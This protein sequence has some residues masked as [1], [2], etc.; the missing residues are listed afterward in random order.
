MWRVLQAAGWLSLLSTGVA[1]GSLFAQEVPAA[2]LLTAAETEFFEARIRPVLVEHCYQCHAS[3]GEGIKGGLRLDHLGGW[4]TGGDSGPAVLP[5]NPEESLLLQAMKYESYEMPPDGQ[6]PVQV[7]ADFEK[8]IQMGAPDPRI[9]PPAGQA[10]IRTIDLATERN[11]WSFQP[12]QASAVPTVTDALWPRTWIDRYIRA[13]QEQQQVTP[14]PDL[15]FERL[16]RRL[17]YDLVGL[18][19]SVEEQQQF[20]QLARTDLESALADAVDRRIESPEFGMHWGRHW[21]DVARYADS[22]GGDFNATFHDAWRYRDYVV[23]SYNEDKPFDQFIREQVA[24]D[25]LPAKDDAQREEQI[26]ATGFLMIGPK[27]LSERD[28]DKLRM[29]IV[30]EQISSV[31]SAFLGMT[32]GCCRCH[33]HKF[34]PIPTNDYYALAGIFRSTQVLDGESQKYV[35]DFTRVDLPIEADHA[36][37]LERHSQRMKSI[38]KQLASARKKRDALKSK[39]ASQQSLG[40]LVDDPQAT[41][42]G[43]WTSSTNV[44]PWVGAGYVHD[45]RLE[46]G[47]KSIT[48]TPDLKATGEYEV[49]FSFCYSSGRDTQV[50]VRIKHAAG[51]SLVHVD[52][53]REPPID[54]LFVVLGRFPF[55]AGQTGS[56]TISNTGTTGYV[57][58]DAVQFIPVDELEQSTPDADSEKLAAA[59]K[60]AGADVKRI[61]AE[62][63]QA[64]SE[65]PPR[66]PQ[67]IAVREATDL[68]D[69][70]VCIRGEHQRPGAIVPRGFLQVAL[71]E[72]PPQIPDDA[73]GRREL[74]DWLADPRNP[75]TA[76]VYVNRIWAHLLGEGLVRTTDNF[77]TLGD[78]P[79]HPQLLDRLA[80]Q[81]IL[82]GWSTKHLV[83]EIMLS[84]VY[85]Q[86][87]TDRPDVFRLDPENRLLW[88]ANRKRLP[89]EA[90]RDTML[91]VSG[92]LDTATGGS[93]VERLGVLVST[94]SA[95]DKGYNRSESSRRSLYMPIIRN[96]IPAMLTAFDFA[97]PDFV[98]GRRNET[99]VPAQALLLLN[100]PFVRE[101]AD[102]SAARLLSEASGDDAGRVAWA[103]E[104]ALCRTPSGAEVDRALNFVRA[105]CEPGEASL[106]SQAAPWSRLLQALFA[107]TEFR[108]LD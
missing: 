48:Y 29:D 34:D 97:D 15:D 89:A 95:S 27:M 36:A 101:M 11:F 41:K 42:V 105:L 37:A 21:L 75:L 73:S 17:S 108:L 18:P 100:S 33:D 14:S 85:R 87:A 103:Y 67:A 5:G 82:R 20:T 70:P 64:A 61:E 10:S 13:A 68:G 19:P 1:T 98:T 44:K 12:L 94:N 50:P 90:L 52:Q 58:A 30:D 62:K 63:K 31:G 66:A 83:R 60:S 81:F 56:V 7:I 106:P 26:I 107:S 86:Q 74:G 43:L 99:N 45:D 77:G 35:S 92:E 2:R 102:K 59:I 96:E 72:A 80:S 69:C 39:T 55:D 38:D 9:D 32:L 51:E 84:H 93:P 53:S 6:L 91:L 28:K 57:M 49:R 104:T 25:L 23:R 4:K 78:T 8:W 22:N 88:R 76:R 46:K 71:F 40:V 24:G 16:L 3:A 65:A 47:E 54:K 79:S